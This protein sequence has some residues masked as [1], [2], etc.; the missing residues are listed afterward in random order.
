MSNSF[1]KR[2]VSSLSFEE[3]DKLKSA[4]YARIYDYELG[5]LDEM[6]ELSEGEIALVTGGRRIQAIKDYRNRCG[7][8]LI[9]CKDKIEDWK[10]NNELGEEQQGECAT[11][12]CTE[13][14]MFRETG[15]LIFCKNHP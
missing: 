12:N 8:K 2:L 1:Y 13:P 14:V 4:V 5:N 9:L 6:P 10:K 3:L 15:P 11:R 7:F